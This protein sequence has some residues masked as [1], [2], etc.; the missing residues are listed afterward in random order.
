MVAATYFSQVYGFYDECQRKYG[1]PNV[2]KH[3][4]DLFDFLPLAALIANSIF[5]PHG[6]LSP[7]IDSLDHIMTL[8]RLQEIPHEVNAPNRFP[9]PCPPFCSHPAFRAHSASSGTDLRLDVE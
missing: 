1:N 2:W 5:C 9:I 3:F 4:T 7:S 8:D 6:G